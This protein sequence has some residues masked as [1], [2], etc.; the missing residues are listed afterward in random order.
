[1][2]LWEKTKDGVG[3]L[4][5]SFFQND[6]YFPRPV[7]G[8]ENYAG[9]KEGYLDELKVVEGAVAEAFFQQ[10]ELTYQAKKETL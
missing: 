8:E 7:L 4:V 2:R 6:P 5:D 9:F 3:V 10:L 1:M